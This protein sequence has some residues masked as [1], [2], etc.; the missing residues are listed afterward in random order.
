MTVTIKD[1]QYEVDGKL[2]WDTEQLQEQYEVIGFGHGYCAAKRK[3]D[4]V[5]GSL[6]FSDFK[7]VWNGRLYYNFY[8]A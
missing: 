6:E 2:A 8:P 3:L 4:G 7:G 1:G 5:T